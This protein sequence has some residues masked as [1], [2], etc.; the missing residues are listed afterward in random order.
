MAE[1]TPYQKGI[2]KRYYEHRETL[3]L[4]KLSEIVSNLYLEHHKGKI[5]RAWKSALAHLLAAGANELRARKIFEE[6]DLEGLARLL[7]ELT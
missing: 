1:H 6:R 4:Q 3:A 2:I 7:S 5:E